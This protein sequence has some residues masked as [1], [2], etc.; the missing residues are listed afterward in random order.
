MKRTLTILTAAILTATAAQAASDIAEID[1]NGDRFASFGEMMIAFPGI[2]SEDFGSIDTNGDNRIDATELYET[3]A[4]S[5]LAPYEDQGREIRV[6]ADRDGDGF[7]D[8]DELSAVY[9]GL[10]QLSFDDID[11]NDDNRVD[12]FEFYEPEAQT[13]LARYEMNRE[14]FVE[15]DTLDADGDNFITFEELNAVYGDLPR[16]SFDDMDGNDDQRLDFTE[17]YSLEAQ[18]AIARHDGS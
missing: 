1:W 8:F 13:I 18:N 16:E 17:Y 5:I 9:S 11:L 3:S 4:Q 6:V 7:A 2:D 12:T 14:E 10:T 15:L